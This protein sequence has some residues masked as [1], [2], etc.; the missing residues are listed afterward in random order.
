MEIEYQEN[1]PESNREAAIP[2]EIDNE[3]DIDSERGKPSQLAVDWV[4][5]CSTVSVIRGSQ[6]PLLRGKKPAGNIPRF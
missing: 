2:I 4:I 6:R 5:G 3:I 1:Q